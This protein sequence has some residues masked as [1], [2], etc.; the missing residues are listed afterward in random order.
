MLSDL[1]R[2]PIPEPL[3]PGGWSAA[4]YATGINDLDARITRL[5]KGELWIFTSAPGQ[6]RS[7]LLTQIATHLATQHRV[8]TWFVSSRDP[9]HIVSARAHS[10]VGRVPLGDFQNDRIE[11]SRSR[12]EAARETLQTAPM[13]VVAHRHAASSVCDDPQLHKLAEP[14]TLFF[15]DPDIEPGWDLVQAHR[16]AQAGDIV[17]VTLPRE[18]VLPGNAYHCDVEPAMRL[19]ESTL[20]GPVVMLLSPHLEVLAETETTVDYLRALLPTP[21]DRAHTGL[22]EDR[23]QVVL[24]G[25]LGEVHGG[26]D[27]S[28]VPVGFEVPEQFGRRTDLVRTTGL[29]R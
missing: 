23:L 13:R 12:V 8:P 11:H 16:L 19:A 29:P 2:F 26:G 18:Q 15:Y 10:A 3:L 9:A 27:L 5:G 14:T 28:G 25:V 17:V 4:R 22:G 21:Q 6:G 20:D 7:T 1:S 24:D